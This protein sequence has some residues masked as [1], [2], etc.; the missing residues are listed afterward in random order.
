M[1]NTYFP[2]SAIVE[3]EKLK[4]ALIL[5]AINPSIG[6]VLIFGEK[7][8]AKSTAVRGLKNILGLNSSNHDIPLVELPLSA[9]EEMIVGTINIPNTLKTEQ[10][11]IEYGL[12]HKAHNGIIYIDEVNL[13]EDH[14]VD[15]IL[16]AAAMGINR[17]E[18]EGVSHEHPA[19]FILVGTM[20][21]EEGELRPQ[22]LDRFGISA[23]VVTETAIATR[24][25]I[26]YRRLEWETEN[27]SFSEK[28]QQSEN[29]I[30]ESIEKAKQLL[31][32]VELSEQ[33]LELA[34]SIALQANVEGHR[35]DII[36]SKTAKTLAA[37][38]D[39]LEVNEGDI[40][41]AAEY[42]LNH[43]TDFLPS[44][45]SD[46]S[47]D[48]QPDNR[49]DKSTQ[50]NDKEQRAGNETQSFQAEQP[51]ATQNFE[52]LDIITDTAKNN[53]HGKIRD[54]AQNVRR[55]KVIGAMDLKA[56]TANHSEIAFFPTLL[57]GIRRGKKKLADIG[58]DDLRF[59]RRIS[60]RKELHVLVVDTSA[61][62]G[63]SKRL[64]YAKGLIQR[65]LKN[66][67]QKK[68]YVAVV[69][70][71]G[72]CAQVV[73]KPTRN[74]M[75]IDKVLDSIKAKGKTPLLHAIEC[76]LNLVESFHKQNKFLT[77]LLIVISDGKV[78][79]PFRNSMNEDLN[80]LGKRIK[81]LS[82]NNFIV[83]SN[84]KFNRSFLLQK[85][86][87]IFGGRYMVMEDTL[88]Q[89]KISL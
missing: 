20:N 62:M 65:I 40:Y 15:V 82:L 77:N 16:D 84:Q 85:M 39:R 3:Q 50:N 73:L 23:R 18:R 5:N 67:Y 29:E 52:T 6:G 55:G 68:S 78:N 46:E 71:Q 37:L 24:K 58:P 45:P 21:P 72:D 54:K 76:S 33:Y 7:G 69:G 53:T 34:I 22:L 63:A 81:K 42:A 8:T 1:T 79:V 83:D 26:V 87:R 32:K 13:L 64:S 86:V 89:G 10:I 11:Q 56:R 17:I 19:N 12:L 36:I 27:Q 80:Y 88:L 41:R 47:T 44:P 74:F 66:G 2:F 43:R 49:A 70:T 38:E 25:E 57:K 4:E 61:S 28:W 9:T 48:N 30:A 31:P 59:K 60:G 75:Q 51:P 35:V 14:L